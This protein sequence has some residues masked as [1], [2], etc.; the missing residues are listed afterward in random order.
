M[1]KLWNNVKPN[2][3]TNFREQPED[4]REQR[5]YKRGKER[6]TFRASEGVE[7]Q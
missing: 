3:S 7:I 1:R 2:H 4:L 5:V 6:K